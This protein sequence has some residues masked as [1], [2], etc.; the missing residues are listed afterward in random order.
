MP[1]NFSGEFQPNIC[2]DRNFREKCLYIYIMT[3]N[4]FMRRY[5]QYMQYHDNELCLPFIPEFCF[6]NDI[7]DEELESLRNNFPN[8]VGRALEMMN[9]R[10]EFLLQRGAVTKKLDKSFV[11]FALKQLGWKD[12]VTEEKSHSINFGGDITKWSK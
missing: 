7:T 3:C 1:K 6:E 4:E 8:K 10:R 12:T 11:V 9:K 2:L 5:N